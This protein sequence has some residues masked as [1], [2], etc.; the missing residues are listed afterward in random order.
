MAE[1][2]WAFFT[3]SFVKMWVASFEITSSLPVPDYDVDA[4]S[5]VSEEPDDEA[6]LHTAFLRPSHVDGVRSKAAGAPP[7]RP[8]PH[9][10]GAAFPQPVGS[11]PPLSQAA[12]AAPPPPK[13]AGAT[14][15][16]RATQ[17]RAESEPPR[18]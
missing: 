7:P 3:S 1:R 6:V 14:G 2:S 18:T 10:A 4:S 17:P 13:A 8:A 15:S 16:G 11:G 5:L 9:A 12:S